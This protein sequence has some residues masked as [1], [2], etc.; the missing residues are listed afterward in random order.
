MVNQLTK[1][2]IQTN[3][4]LRENIDS[5]QLGKM[6]A[7]IV[8][9]DHLAHPATVHTLVAMT[10]AANVI[11]MLVATPIVTMVVTTQIKMPSPV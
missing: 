3:T 7:G 10:P 6:A 2:S 9:V 4:A 11:R 5:M 1:G 8:T